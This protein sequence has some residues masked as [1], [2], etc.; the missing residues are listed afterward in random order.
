MYSIKLVDLVIIFRE[1]FGHMTL[2]VLFPTTTAWLLVLASQMALRAGLTR[3]YHSGV[4][5]DLSLLPFC[6]RVGVVVC[7]MPFK[8]VSAES[9]GCIHG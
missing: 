2:N 6:S 4:A 7:Y 5:S 8:K 3:L 9:S 1:G